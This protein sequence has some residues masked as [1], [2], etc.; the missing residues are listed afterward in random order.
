MSTS[1]SLTFTDAGVYDAAVRAVDENGGVGYS[2]VFTIT[3]RNLDLTIN[4]GGTATIDFTGLFIGGPAETTTYE[5]VVDDGAWTDLGRDTVF[6][7]T[8]GDD[9]F[10]TGVLRATYGNGTTQTENFTIVVHNLA[11]VFMGNLADRTVDRDETTVVDFT[12]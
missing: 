8:Y 9:G 4:E 12:G 7:L 6:R 11:P 2:D 1:F 5:Y 3:A 10:H